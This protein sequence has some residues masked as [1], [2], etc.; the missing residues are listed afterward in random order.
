MTTA[1]DGYM[2]ARDAAAYVGT[3]YRGFDQWVRRHAVPHVRYGRHRRFSPA[4]L[5]R[6]LRTM[7]QRAEQESR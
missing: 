4:T 7:Q 1:G 5:D 6:V 3:T 2:S